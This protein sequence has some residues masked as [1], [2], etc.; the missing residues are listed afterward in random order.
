M[1]TPTFP[2]M[3][4]SLYVS[5]IEHTVAFYN[6]FFGQIAD[7]LKPGYA[8]YMLA[9]PSLIISFVENAELVNPEFGHM[10]FQVAT[11]EELDSRMEQDRAHQLVA[12][13]EMDTACCYAKQDKYWVADP[14]NYLWEV[15]YFHEDVEFNDP[16]YETGESE[17]CCSPAM[18][19]E[20]PKVTIAEISTCCEP[21]SDCC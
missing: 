16:R 18:K 5:N 8:K 17:A 12:L 2:H 1:D 6:K 4:V 15:Y 10:G 3:H 7:K 20:K 11:R 9:E 21:N 13:E 14:D 19:T